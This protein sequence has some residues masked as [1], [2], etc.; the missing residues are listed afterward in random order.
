[1][2]DN[3]QNNSKF[4]VIRNGVESNIASEDIR[5]GEILKLNKDEIVPCDCILLKVDDVSGIVN[6]ST[7]S[8]DG[9]SNL[10]PRISIAQSEKI[11]VGNLTT[12]QPN[13]NMHVFNGT[14]SMANLPEQYFSLN[15]VLLKGVKVKSPWVCYVGAIFVAKDTRI[16]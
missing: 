2:A 6:V 4:Q 3:E 8:L 15:N 5:V 1:M 12:S 10:K 7:A 16:M 13:C 11:G 14:F 9:E